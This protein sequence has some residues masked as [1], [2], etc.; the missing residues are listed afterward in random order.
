[1][2]CWDH[3]GKQAS[4]SVSDKSGY[5]NYSNSFKGCGIWHLLQCTQFALY[6]SDVIG[7]TLESVNSALEFFFGTEC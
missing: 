5:I 1:M 6:N 4:F 3:D 7:A 2:L